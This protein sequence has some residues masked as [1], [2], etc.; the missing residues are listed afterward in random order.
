VNERQAGLKIGDSVRIIPIVL[1]TVFLFTHV[2]EASQPVKRTLTGCVIGNTFYIIYG[3]NNR[4]AHR[5][6]LSQPLDLTLYEGKT[7][8]IHG[9]LSPSDRF[10][11]NEGTSPQ[12]L[13]SSC[14][15]SDKKAIDKLF[16]IQH[17]VD[18]KKA[19]RKGEFSEAFLL[20]SK[21]L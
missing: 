7:V 11:L 15:I 3:I 20:I 8:R 21:A 6:R 18:A 16:I 17:R 9:W 5:I 10:S 19:A 14:D 1:L 4:G 13:K 2:A 12:I